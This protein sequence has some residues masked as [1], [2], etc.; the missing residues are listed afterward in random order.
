MTTW[1]IWRLC[2]DGV[3][4]MCYQ[5]GN[6]WSQ[7]WCACTCPSVIRKSR[8]SLR[9]RLGNS[10]LEKYCHWGSLCFQK[11][12]DGKYCASRKSS[13]RRSETQIYISSR[14]Y[15]KVSVLFCLFFM[16]STRVTCTPPTEMNREFQLEKN[17]RWG[18]PREIFYEFDF[19][20]FMDV[21]DR[22][23]W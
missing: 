14:H 19:S 22:Y 13:Y 11:Q 5:K 9:Q 10:Q 6:N 18:F 23:S 20:S 16:Q 2:Y 15:V 17:V 8:I 7:Y 3:L 12:E 1:K 21:P 4:H